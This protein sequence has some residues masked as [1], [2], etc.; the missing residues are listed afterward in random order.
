M[1]QLN[2]T[3]T[4][5]EFSTLKKYKSGSWKSFLISSVWLKSRVVKEPYMTF[6]ESW[7]IDPPIQIEKP[8]HSTGYCPY[9]IIVE[10]FPI[11]KERDE[12]SCTVFGHDCPAFRCAEPLAEHPPK[13]L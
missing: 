1:P 9:G 7:D 6:G 10:A 2:I 3:L 5:E 11:K 13:A 4:D 8:C 12:V